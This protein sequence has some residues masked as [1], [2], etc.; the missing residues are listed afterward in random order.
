[1]DL[2]S[3]LPPALRDLPPDRPV[4]IA[5]PTA[6]G[7]SAL[8]MALARAQGGIIVNADAM[9]VFDGW[10]ILSARPTQAD[11]AA[12]PHA[13][14]GHLPL[15]E[16]Y[17]V[18][19]WLADLEPVL[20]GPLRPIIVG[21][22]GLYFTA[23]TRGL[24]LIPP[25][26]AEVRAR[27]DALPL[28]ALR[29]GLDPRT[30]ARID[31]ANRARVQR[32]W[33]VLTATGQGLADWQKRTPAPRLPLD[34]VTPLILGPDPAWLADRITRRFDTMLAAGLLDEA[35]RILPI[36]DPRHASARTIGAA[37]L[38]AHLRGEITLDAARDAAITATRQYA[39]RQ[40]TWFRNRMEGWITLSRP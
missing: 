4:L 31:T 27:A 32:A 23:L 7:K 1:M 29:A 40:R 33:E 38:I 28:A 36:W 25:V 10:R 5:G 39:K 15:A 26:P 19:A 21:G 8:A 9:Q 11:E 14:Y 34:Q 18:G 12:L 3:A 6:S 17:S 16:A 20:R 37:G 2:P 30:R 24:A 22:T 13:L 35:R